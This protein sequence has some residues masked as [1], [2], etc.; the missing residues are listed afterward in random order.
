MKLIIKIP[1]GVDALDALSYVE[2]RIKQMSGAGMRPEPN[3][4]RFDLDFGFEHGLGWWKI[5]P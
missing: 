5:E 3:P 4:S 2:D 1:D